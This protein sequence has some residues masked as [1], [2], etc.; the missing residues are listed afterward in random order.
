MN[1]YIQIVEY[2]SVVKRS[3]LSIHDMTR[4]NFN[5]ILLS[6]RI[7]SEMTAYCVIIRWIL[8]VR[9]LSTLMECT[10]SRV[11]SNVNMDFR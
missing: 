9:H 6:E 4:R 3:E 1:W 8:V 11:N 10:M 7:Q 2:Y 5:S